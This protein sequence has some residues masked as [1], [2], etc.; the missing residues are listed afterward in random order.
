M[1]ELEQL[2]AASR[3]TPRYRRKPKSQAGPVVV[4]VV[5]LVAIVGGLVWWVVRQTSF[6]AISGVTGGATIDPLSQ[7]SGE[8]QQ[9]AKDLR[10]AVQ[11]LVAF[12]LVD[13]VDWD[14]RVL[15]VRPVEWAKAGDDMH[16]KSLYGFYTYYALAAEQ[17]VEARSPDGKVLAEWDP[18]SGYRSFTGG[19]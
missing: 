8:K 17:R 6:P 4:V 7:T 11:S 15:W 13:K 16:R 18:K 10:I 3:T 14:K 9:T 12:G 19:R 5:V 2:A 1:S